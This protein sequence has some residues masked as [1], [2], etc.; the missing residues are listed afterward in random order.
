M[1]GRLLSGQGKWTRPR[2]YRRETSHAAVSD[3]SATRAIIPIC[4]ESKLSLPP[5]QSAAKLV[6][7]LCHEHS[8]LSSLAARTAPRLASAII[9]T[10][11]L[12]T[13]TATRSRFDRGCVDVVCT[14]VKMSE[15]IEYYTSL[16]ADA[17]GAAASRVD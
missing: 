1:S 8:E 5:T 11:E 13:V 3:I 15:A 10:P 12:L 14:G 16:I 4:T 9:F 7:H 6:A 2:P 17:R